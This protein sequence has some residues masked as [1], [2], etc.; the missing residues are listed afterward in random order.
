M[1][2]RRRSMR[3]DGQAP[4]GGE[5]RPLRRSAGNSPVVVLSYAYSGARHVQE[6]LA[7]DT[8][9][10]CTVASGVIPL[11]EVAAETWQRVEGRST[12]ALSRL[13]VS[14][15]RGIVSAQVTV[16]LGF[17]GKSRWCELATATP[18]A[19]ESFLQVFPHAGIVC[20]HRASL[21]VIRAG[22]RASPWGLQGQGLM[23]YILSHPG[24]SVAALGAY[25]AHSTEQLLV[26]EAEH[27]TAAHRVLYEDVA[28]NPFQALITARASLGLHGEVSGQVSP[29][30]MDIPAHGAEP[31]PSEQ[32]VPVEMIP[33]PLR[34]RITHLHAQLGYPPLRK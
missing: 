22:V 5:E 2:W 13:A 12:Q 31:Q 11:C 4:A 17:S 16:M 6:A 19:V 14:T 18:S 10:A 23:P 33:E 21:D 15:I 30:R 8:E 20:V 7:A 24:N 26:F 29:E 27:P 1:P 25:W 28:G 32:E 34:E 9:L 3:N